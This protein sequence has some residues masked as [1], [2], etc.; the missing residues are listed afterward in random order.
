M[1]KNGSTLRLVLLTAHVLHRPDIDFVQ[2]WKINLENHPC[3]SYKYPRPI[4][5]ISAVYIGML[6]GQFGTW[7]EGRE[8]LQL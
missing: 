5:S 2:F 7:T 8:R 1:I 4:P 3:N 6:S